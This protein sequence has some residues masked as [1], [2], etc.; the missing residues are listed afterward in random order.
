MTF[1]NRIHSRF[2]TTIVGIALLLTAGVRCG[3]SAGEC[4]GGICAIG[5]ELDVT[6]LLLTSALYAERIRMVSD[7]LNTWEVGSLN[8]SMDQTGTDPHRISFSNC[9]ESPEACVLALSLHMKGACATQKAAGLIERSQIVIPLE[10]FAE[11]ASHPYELR[12]K[13]VVHEIGHCLGLEHAE[14]I[15]HVMA[16]SLMGVM[17]PSQTERGAVRAVYDQQLPSELVPVRMPG[18]PV[19]TLVL[20]SGK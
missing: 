3:G 16:P 19:F 18:D 7:A 5:E 15:N 6:A 10:F 11:L 4:T 8:V 2:I 17:E 12:R 9:A 13:V 14:T 20:P 1:W